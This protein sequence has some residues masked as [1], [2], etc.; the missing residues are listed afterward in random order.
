MALTGLSNE[1]WSKEK[2]GKDDLEVSVLS[3]YWERID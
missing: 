1:M 2:K 3:N